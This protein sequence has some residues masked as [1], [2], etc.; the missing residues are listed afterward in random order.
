MIKPKSLPTLPK[1][2]AR[3]LEPLDYFLLNDDN[4][5]RVATV[6]DDGTTVTAT[7]THLVTGAQIVFTFPADEEVSVLPG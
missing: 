7:L 1:R 5:A 6:T 4:A 2:R 3:D